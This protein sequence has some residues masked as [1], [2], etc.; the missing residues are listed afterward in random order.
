[1]TLPDG[2]VGRAELV[3]GSHVISVGLAPTDS[4]GR[5]PGDRNSVGAMT[6]VFVADV[7]ESLKFY[8]QIPGAVLEIS[9]NDL[10]ALH[11][12]VSEAGMEPD[13]PP[14]DRHWGERALFVT[15]PDGNDIEFAAG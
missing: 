5:T 10:D 14:D 11:T 2:K 6:L 12:Q 3:V 13:G 15:D 7:E 8:Q 9:T 1:M 4:G